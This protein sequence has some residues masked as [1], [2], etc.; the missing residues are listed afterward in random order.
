MS[1]QKVRGNQNVGFPNVIP[2][3]D[4]QFGPG[5]SAAV[6]GFSSSARPPFVPAPPPFVPRNVDT[7]V[8]NE[9]NWF[10]NKVAVLEETVKDKDKKVQEYKKKLSN[11]TKECLSKD[12]EIAEIIK[13][14][15]AER[16]MIKNELNECK[17]DFAI[18]C[19]EKKE[20][21]LK[22]DKLIDEISYFEEKDNESNSFITFESDD[23]NKWH[24][25]EKPFESEMNKVVEN[26]DKII[27]S[28]QNPKSVS[29]KQMDY[30]AADPQAQMDIVNDILARFSKENLK[31]LR[32]VL[33][34]N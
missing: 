22:I 20:L 11:V 10:K 15:K 28:N 34:K 6:P 23:L 17:Q 18:A 19:L 5:H 31:N 14:F 24:E 1:F 2:H 21:Q 30:V 33:K 16:E 27:L 3:N 25:I 9:L 13:H 12:D 8:V 32:S 4:T 7:H 29:K 26:F